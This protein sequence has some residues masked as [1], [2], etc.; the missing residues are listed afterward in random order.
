MFGK[1]VSDMSRRRNSAKRAKEIMNTEFLCENTSSPIEVK[2]HNL[3][4]IGF[5]HTLLFGLKHV[6]K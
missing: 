2:N 3:T 4:P 6:T 1:A 5:T